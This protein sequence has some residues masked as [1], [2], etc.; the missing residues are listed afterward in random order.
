MLTHKVRKTMETSVLCWLATADSR[1]RP[2]VS[3]KEVFCAFDDRHLV[4]ANIASPLSA[5]NIDENPHVCVSL[6]DILVQKGHKLVGSAIN[7]RRRATGYERW[8]APL[9]PVVADRFP[10]RS[11]FV[12]RVERVAEIVAPS[13][14]LFPESTSES[15]QIE[16]AEAAYGVRRLPGA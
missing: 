9:R 10:V 7:V 4:I 1:G 2:N 11:V 12:V 6:V 13:Y 16:A 14:L 8:L 15:L 5:K 3:P